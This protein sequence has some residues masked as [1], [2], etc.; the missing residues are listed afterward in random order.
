MTFVPEPDEIIHSIDPD[1]P[2]D[3]TG[4]E[5]VDAWRGVKTEDA[6]VATTGLA[7]LLRSRSRALLASLL[8]PHKKPVAF[9]AV[10]V[11]VS[12][13]CQLA[14]PWLVKQGIDRGIPPLLDGGSGAVRPLATVIIAMLVVTVASAAAYNGFLLL[15]GRVGQDV[16]F[17]LRLRAF[18]HFQRLSLS[19][20]ENYT[21][22]RVISRQTSDVESVAELLGQ[23]IVNL[24]TSMLLIVGIGVVLLFLDLPL[25]LVSL[26]SFPVL[27]ALTR[28][29]RNRSETAYRAVSESVALVIVHFV[30]SLGGIQAVHA[31]RR[32]PRNQEIFEYLD[33]R[34]RLANRRSQMLAAAYGPGVQLLGRLS[35]A[36]VLL[37]GGY[38]VVDGQTSVGVLAAFLL[39]LRRFFA[40]MEEL[41]QFY[42]LFQA[43][44][45]GLEKLS[46]ILD[47]PPSVP[48]PEH[49]VPL[50]AAR[51]ELRFEEVVFGYRDRVVLH[52]LDLE[53]P[54]GQSIAVVGATGAGKTTLSRLAARFWDPST[55]V[56]RLDGIDLRKVGDP[57]VRRAVVTVTQENFLFS[58]TVADNIRLGKPGASDAEVEEAARAIGAHTFIADLPEGYATDVHQKGARLSSGQRQLVAFARA[59]LADPA[60][61]ILDEA[62][63]SL[64]LPSER[65]VQRALRTLLADRTA[66]II[67]HRLS[68]VEIADRVLVME[69][70]RI[71]EDGSPTELVADGGRY[72]AL[73]QAW[74]DSLA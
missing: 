49:P 60:V 23:G 39:Y 54:A 2:L 17:D 3:I 62:T 52:H 16:V 12:T 40:P 57:D 20:H 59:F 46:G 13:G 66:I 72:A 51:G 25:A 41:S 55:G 69:E 31:F 47:E 65:L 58:G 64:D 36:V 32:E 70:G 37:Y 27:F 35:T 68:T 63:S 30:E 34:Y 18:R 19:F 56:V 53:I 21:S 48:E 71:V 26:A 38:R 33:D 10:L 5:R 29:F 73:H 9:A 74:A 11:A 15:L 8:R 45:A 14:I 4:D 7:G 50:P 1:A 61:L 24:I 67:A 22:G 43:A 28:W 6:D 42:N 44:A